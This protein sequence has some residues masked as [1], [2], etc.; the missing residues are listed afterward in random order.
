M[1]PNTH[2]H[3]CRPGSFLFLCTQ[4]IAVSMY[5]VTKNLDTTYTVA[6]KG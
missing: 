5:L 1:P 6:L 2:L 4:N 3:T